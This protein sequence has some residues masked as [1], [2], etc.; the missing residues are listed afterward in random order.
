MFEQH[1]PRNIFRRRSTPNA[2]PGSAG[3]SLIEMM[4]VLAILLILASVTTIS[5]QPVVKSQRVTTSY[6]E[7]LTALRH[8]HDQAAADMR[9]YV[10]SFATPGT[11]TVTQNTTAGPVLFTTVLPSDITIHLEP[12]FPNSPT[13]APTTPDGFGTASFPIDFSQGIGPGGG[14]TI[15]FQ[16]DGTAMDI[17]GNINN[18]VVYFGRPG[19]V[20]SSRA[21]T[22]WGMTGRIRGWR[23]YPSGAQNVWRQQ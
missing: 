16:P 5:L 8:A 11:I 18:G 10:V 3:W 13:V 9:V 22:V 19:D 1:D 12:G 6:N 21:I 4:T 2:L 23:L 15:Y 20:Y 7:V 17:N 14:T